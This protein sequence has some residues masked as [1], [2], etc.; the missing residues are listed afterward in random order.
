MSTLKALI[1]AAL[2]RR[3]PLLKDASTNAYRLFNGAGD[4]LDGLIIERFDEVMI[5]QLHEQRLNYSD[6]DLRAA[7]ESLHQ[8]LGTRAV[9]KK[10]F[11]R[12]RGD[13]PPEIAALHHAPAPWIGQPVSPEISILENGLRFIISPYHG[14]S[15]GLFLEHRENRRRIRELSPNRWVLNTFCYTGSFSVA[16]VAGGAASVT[17]VDLS[18]TYLAWC[19]QNFTTNHLETE[20]HW[21]F[22]SDVLEFFQ[23]ARRQNR[24]YDLII[25]DPPSFGRLR[26]PARVF[27]LAEQ[28]DDL[29]RQAVERLDP[30]GIVLLAV[31]HRQISRTRLEEALA[32]T[33]R[34]CSILERPVLP[35]DFAGDPDYAKSVIARFD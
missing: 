29:V 19:R 35:L 3:Q 34:P 14:F 33:G 20:G 18:K 11:L 15:V 6:E 7:I 10:F 30:G 2:L 16:A 24:R 1:D 22:C 25:L 32:A 9:Y 31:N 8:R 4:G 13:V 17:S 27:V 5:V 23:R 21:F 12:D 28:L 26:R